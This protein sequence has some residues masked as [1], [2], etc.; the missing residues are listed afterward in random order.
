MN[1]RTFL[2]SLVSALTFSWAARKRTVCIISPN[3]RMA[4]RQYNEHVLR[5]FK[6]WSLAGQTIF[7][8]Y[9]ADGRPTQQCAIYLYRG[10]LPDSWAYTG[11][12]IPDRTIHA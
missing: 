10:A 1:R 12:W 9:D 2:T 6:P 8:L 4:V 11:H 7:P 5:G 3:W